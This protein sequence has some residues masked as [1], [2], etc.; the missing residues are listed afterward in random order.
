MTTTAGQGSAPEPW[1]R[2]AAVYQVYLRSFA[3]GN[4]DGVGDFPGLQTRLSYISSLGVDA[5]W[6]TPFYP[7]PMVDGGYDVIDYRAV[8]P[9][10]G[11]MADVEEILD[12]AH[13]LGL[14]VI[15]DL[16]PNHTS[17]QHPW[18]RNAMVGRGHP[19]RD[20]Y[21]FLPAGPGGG[22]PN[23]W[24]SIFG[25]SAWAEDGNGWYFLHLFSSGQPDLNWS[26]ADVR[27][28][29]EATIRFWLDKGLDGIRVDFA[30]G[31]VKDGAYRDNPE[32]CATGSGQRA[33]WEDGYRHC[34]NQPGVHELYRR[35]R[36][37]VDAY[38]GD[39][40][41]SGEVDL[42]RP[43]LVALYARPDEL[44]Q[45]MHLVLSRMRNLW[46]LHGLRLAIDDG[47][48]AFGEVGAVPAWN[49]SNHDVERQVSRLGGG[50]LGRRRARAAALLVI[51][52]PGSLYLYAGEELGL[53]EAAVPP[54]LR[55]D[56]VRPGAEWR[57]RDGCRVP[58]PWTALDRG[59]GFTS[60]EPWLPFP[61]DWGA[62]SVEVQEAQSG[63]LLTLYR[64]ALAV[65][66]DVL[67]GL[68][69]SI[70][71][72]DWGAGVLAFARTGRTGPVAVAVNM[73]SEPARV[74]VDGS[75][76]LGSEPSV[77]LSRGRLELPVDSGAWVTL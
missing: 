52:L 27:E 10:F 55:S 47:L 16:V 50:S 26:N 14:R 43:E 13:G 20:K 45:V 9:V 2:T 44:H 77:S 18:F 49:L 33:S 17:D 38:P 15:F 61:D 66:R 21:H 53:D 68:S 62:R 30:P 25:G 57:P 35:W 28:D 37:V 63:S 71:W 60:G 58:I 41:L 51:G 40:F 3:D 22:P 56:P 12:R 11:S 6:V 48:R 34:L 74:D 75:L 8:D 5:L 67:Q 23:N 46:S 4:G 76:L 39:R 32:D 19:D 29:F 42:G 31:L 7:S 59:H 72:L 69:S 64:Q 1:W 24:T 70:E 73:G 54:E 65:R 36:L